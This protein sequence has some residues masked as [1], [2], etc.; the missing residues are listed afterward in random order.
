MKKEKE[1][2]KPQAVVDIGPVENK[3]NE[4]LSYIKSVE[5]Y[6]MGEVRTIVYNADKLEERVS[7]LEKELAKLSLAQETMQQ[8]ILSKFEELNQKSDDRPVEAIE[9]EVEV[10]A[11]EQ[12]ALN[13][14]EEQEAEQEEEE[15]QEQE[16]ETQEE[17]G[18]EEF[19]YSYLDKKTKKIWLGTDK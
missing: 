3:I 6:A 19:E 5:D 12:E 15:E 18:V 7:F 17:Q 1:V 10:E 2:E 14:D 9:A 13:T 4:A 8:M 11:A 16:D